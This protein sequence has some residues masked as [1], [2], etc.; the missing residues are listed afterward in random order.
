MPHLLRHLPRQGLPAVC[1]LGTFLLSISKGDPKRPSPLWVYTAPCS[2]L[3]H[4]TQSQLVSTSLVLQRQDA[5][6]NS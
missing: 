2:H 3:H 5:H 6:L 1:L 4:C